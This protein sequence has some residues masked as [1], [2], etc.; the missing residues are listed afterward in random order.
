MSSRNQSI[1]RMAEERLDAAA[2][3]SAA[4]L[5]LQLDLVDERSGELI[6]RFGGKWNRHLRD[7]VGDAPRSRVIRLHPGQLDAAEWFDE[8]L[9]GHM[10]GDTPPED[11]VFDAAFTGGRRGGKSALAFTLSVAYAIAVPGSIVWLVCPSDAFFKEPMEYLESI[12][13]VEWYTSLGFPHWTYF[14]PNGSTITLMSGHTPRRLKQG[15]CDFAVINEGQAVPNQSYTTL[16]ASIVDRGG[17]V[18]TAANPPDIGDPGEWV[19]DL[20]GGVES[21][22]LQ[23]AVHFF[24][25]PLNNPHIDQT[26]LQALAEKMDPHTFDVQIRGMYKLPPDAVLHAWDRL[27]NELPVP[28]I[29]SDITRAVTQH[30]EGRAYDDVLGMDV[31]TFPWIA[32]VR[33]RFYR[34]PDAPDDLSKALLWGVGECY[35]DQGDEVDCARLLID[36]HKVDPLRA[37][38]VMD[39]SCDWQQQ[40]RDE[41]KQRPEFRGA[42]SM[43]MMR[44]CG[45]KHVVG[46]DPDMRDNPGVIDRMRAA[47]ARIGPKKGPPLVF[48]DPKRCKKTVTSLRKWK[49]V[50]GK[51][52]RWSKHAHGGDAFTYILWRFFPRRVERGSVDVQSIRRFGGRDRTKGFSR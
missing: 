32:A 45:F 40:Q 8:W 15:R 9:A 44:G 38:V 17:L 47:N 14:L 10:A 49:T 31:Q 48:V 24:F 37:L 3:V 22:E 34:N 4:S 33:T 43:D 18:L 26:A 1:Q 19:A 28:D 51:P 42:G 36:E 27:K 5:D 21:C 30:F 41:H 23:H 25:D 7:Y 12:M 29:G 46:P 6:A 20:V 52:A 50:K 13:P 2:R 35:V 39:A 11:R 16:S